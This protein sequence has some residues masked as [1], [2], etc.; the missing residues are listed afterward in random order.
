MTSYPTGHMRW[1]LAAHQNSMTFLHLDSEGTSTYVTV[2]DGG[3]AWGFLR[4][5]HPATLYHLSTF[6]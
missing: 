6:F 5:R 2:A 3:K 4:Q 1:A